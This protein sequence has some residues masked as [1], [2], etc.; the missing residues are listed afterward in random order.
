MYICKSTHFTFKLALVAHSIN[1]F[2]GGWRAPE[3]QRRAPVFCW[4]GLDAP[5][6]DPLFGGGAEGVFGCKKGSEWNW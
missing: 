3:T 4:Q 6:H 1:K 5:G 2:T